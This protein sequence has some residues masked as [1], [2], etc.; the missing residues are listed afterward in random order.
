MISLLVTKRIWLCL[1]DFKK[2][3]QQIP[4][5][6]LSKVQIL[7]TKNVIKW[8]QHITIA[9]TSHKLLRSFAAQIILNLK[10]V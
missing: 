5:Q 1:A 6:Y 7:Q 2:I 8:L 4:K 9:V 3:L 10:H